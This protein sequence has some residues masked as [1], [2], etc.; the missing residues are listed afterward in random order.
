L[1][2]VFLQ[3]ELTIWFFKPI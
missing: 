1:N 2:I 3:T